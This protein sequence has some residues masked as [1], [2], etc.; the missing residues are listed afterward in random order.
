[1]DTD[2]HRKSLSA[3][4]IASFLFLWLSVEICVQINL[5]VKINLWKMELKDEYGFLL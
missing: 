2:E 4:R 3:M 5:R 1:L